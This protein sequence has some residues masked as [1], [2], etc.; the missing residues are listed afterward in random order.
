MDIE[1]KSIKVNT[2]A[3]D[4][5]HNESVRTIISVNAPSPSETIDLAESSSNQSESEFSSGSESSDQSGSDMESDEGNLNKI[6]KRKRAKI[7][8]L[9]KEV[10]LK[11]AEARFNVSDLVTVSAGVLLAEAKIKEFQKTQAELEKFTKKKAKDETSPKQV[12]EK[13]DQ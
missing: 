10:G 6:M 8:R 9:Q 3:N 5:P 7:E 13:T 11:L 2:G 1:K 4:E 12:P